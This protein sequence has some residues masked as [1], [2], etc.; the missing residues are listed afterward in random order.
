MEIRRATTLELSSTELGELRRLV[1]GQGESALVTG[2]HVLGDGAHTGLRIA[3]D[4]DGFRP[5][6]LV[7]DLQGA[8]LHH[9]L[10]G[11]GDP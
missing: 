6:R 7:L 9:V 8:G 1:V 5:E 4:A 11:G 3:D 10:V 2:R